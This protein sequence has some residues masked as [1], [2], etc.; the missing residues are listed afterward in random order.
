[1]F[2]DAS[3][4]NGR[5]RQQRFDCEWRFHSV[6]HRL[7]GF[8]K[9]HSC[10]GSVSHTFTIQN[11]GA[12]PLAL[13]GTPKVAISGQGAADFTVTLNPA[14]PVV[15]GG[16]TTFTV[17]FKPSKPANR[18]ATISI[19]N[20]TAGE[21]PFTF[22]IKGIGTGTE[23]NIR[24]KGISIPDG[25]TTPSLSD[26]TDFGTQKLKTKISHI[27]TIQNLGNTSLNLTGSPKVSVSGPGAA[28]FTIDAF[29]SSP[30]APSGSTTFTVGFFPTGGGLRK[31]ILSIANN[32]A[33]ENPYTFA[34]QGTGDAPEISVKGKG[35]VISNGDVTPSL[36]DNTDFGF[37][38]S[39]ND[40]VLHIFTIENLG[41]R[42]LNLT[43]TPKVSF[44]NVNKAGV[45]FSIVS[46][47]GQPNCAWRFDK[48]HNRI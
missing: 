33:N 23:I 13:T 3:A 45:D 8:R 46:T 26:G 41:T 1:M 35:V 6:Y 9:C 42:P 44:V 48:L 5:G 19:A 16:S 15:V 24:S 38:T 14:S 17:R 25:D 12:T 37:V 21:N 30:V 47:T 18:T 36:A 11:F 40:T 10:S 43:G 39:K 34:I 7:H 32:D 2:S 31:A 22:T 20:S 4:S 29:P 27:F 28:D